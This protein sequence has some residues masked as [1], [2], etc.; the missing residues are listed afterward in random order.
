MPG[1]PLGND[2]K[3]VSP[4]NG[5]ELVDITAADHV[6]SQG[7]VRAISFAVAGDLKVTTPYNSAAIVI[8]SGALA[9]GI[10]HG[11]VVKSVVKVGTL[12]TGIVGYY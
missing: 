4:S 11:L 3:S 9:A 7:P 2:T 10:Q 5:A 1:S 12:A 6:F 8:P